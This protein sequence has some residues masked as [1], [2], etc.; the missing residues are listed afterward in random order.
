MS[1]FNPLFRV[2][3]ALALAALQTFAAPQATATNAH[4]ASGAPAL[5]LETGAGTIAVRLFPDAAPDVVAALLRLTDD[6]AEGTA[7]LSGVPFTYTRP[8]VELR[9]AA[10]SA[11]LSYPTR[12]DARALALDAQRL[13]TPGDAMNALQDELLPAYRRARRSGTATPQLERWVQAWYEDFDAAFLIGV[14]R[15]EL[16]E[17]LGHV[18]TGGLA[19]RAVRRGTVALV[20]ASPGRSSSRLSIAL[21]DLP[22]RTGTWMVVGEVVDGLD[23]ASAI[24]TAPLDRPRHVRSRTHAPRDPVLI[25]TA[26]LE[27]G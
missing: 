19:S 18:Y 9:T 5:R 4:C 22:E 26:R 24:A 7:T 16:N 6:G 1:D 17:A 14:S 25:D 21:T 8:N 3:A 13:E 2:A 15:Q 11:S 27:C 10:V 12:I 20:P 23:T